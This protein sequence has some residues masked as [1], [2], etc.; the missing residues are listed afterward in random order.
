MEGFNNL[1]SRD[2]GQA[3]RP[4]PPNHDCF[5]D[6]ADDLFSRLPLD[7]KVG[8]HTAAIFRYIDDKTGGRKRSEGT[9]NVD[10]VFEFG[11]G[12]VVVADTGNVDR[13]RRI[14]IVDGQGC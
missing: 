5:D 12:M 10:V 6:G 3:L 4:R 8:A 9:R 13:F 2:E 11:A 7:N 1:A 14:D